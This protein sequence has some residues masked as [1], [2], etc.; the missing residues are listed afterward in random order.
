M[1][2]CSTPLRVGDSGAAVRCA[3]HQMARC[4]SSHS[5]LPRSLPTSPDLAGG[6]LLPPIPHLLL[7][8][9]LLPTPSPVPPLRC[10]ASCL[11][12]Y[13][14]PMQVACIMVGARRENSLEPHNLGMTLTGTGMLWVG[15]FGCV[16]G[17]DPGRMG[18]RPGCGAHGRPCCERGDG[19][20][21]T[22]GGCGSAE[23]GASLVAGCDGFATGFASAQQPILRSHL[24][25]QRRQR[26]RRQ[27]RRSHGHRGHPGVRA[28]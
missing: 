15:W 9:L 16:A 13:S 4:R 11:R 1:R 25:V 20:C 8:L 24:Q 10:C 21:C 17:S 2:G 28:A 3:V 23:G 6:L 22:W 18:R 19:S 14:A 12:P 26:A 5:T 7:A 27:C